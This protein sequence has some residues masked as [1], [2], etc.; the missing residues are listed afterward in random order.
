MWDSLAA[1]WGGVGVSA[2]S[3]PGGAL[4]SRRAL[5]EAVLASLR[6]QGFE[7]RDGVVAA[8]AEIDKER[9][10]ALTAA[11]VERAVERARRGLARHERRLIGH[12]ADG[13]TLR[14]EAIEP[15]LVAV[16][17]GSEE[18]LLFRW[19]RL[20]WS[21]PTGAGYGR[22]LRF[23]VMDAA[24]GKLVGLL[25]LGDPVFSLGPRDEWVGWDRLRRS[26]ALRSVLHVHLLGAAPPYSQLLGAKLV[27]LLAASVEVRTAF[28]ARYAGRATVVSG[29]RQDGRLALLTTIGSL[30]RSSIFNRLRYGDETMGASRLVWQCVGHTLGS[31]QYQFD[32]ELQA[33]LAAHGMAHCRLTS[34]PASWG[35]GPRSRREAIDKALVAIGFDPRALAYG[36][37]EIWCAPLAAN[38]PAFLRGQDDDLDPF[39]DTAEQLA[40]HWRERWLLPRIETEDRHRS[41]RPSSWRLWGAQSS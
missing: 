30:G 11:S 33:A 34:K 36:V 29:T 2:A 39:L 26:A 13:R 21:V 41:F 24:N 5:R 19:A 27:A 8:P 40:T 7:L 10:R 35:R 3:G 18:E 28:S 15:R 38:A 14:P 37:R 4:R 23:L 25:G 1:A 31:A 16:A 20:H 9:L 12:L 17:S 22:R 32:H 6:T